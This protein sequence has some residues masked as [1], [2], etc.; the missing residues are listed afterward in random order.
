MLR[1]QQRAAKT[2]QGRAVPQ[3]AKSLSKQR[4]W[5]RS[6]VEVAVVLHLF[7]IHELALLKFI[8][9]RT[10][11]SASGLAPSSAGSLLGRKSCRQH[12]LQR[13]SHRLCL[14]HSHSVPSSRPRQ[15]L[16]QWDLQAVDIKLNLL[17]YFPLVLKS[18]PRE[19]FFPVF[20]FLDYRQKS[21]E[22]RC[23]RIQQQMEDAQTDI[24]EG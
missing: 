14:R 18:K 12:R 22:S 1:W 19:T 24:A 23:P 3:P 8:R 7:T 17:T 6:R 15:T 20:P 13:W 16:L 9:S 21:G 4:T 5:R 10:R 11:C 2:C